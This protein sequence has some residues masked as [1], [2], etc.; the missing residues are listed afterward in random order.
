M[1]K[2]SC[3]NCGSNN[4]IR[5]GMGTTGPVNRNNYF[6]C[7]CK[8]IF[9]YPKIREGYYSIELPEEGFM[10][11]FILGVAVTLVVVCSLVILPH[12]LAGNKTDFSSNARYQ[13]VVGGDFDY[14][15]DTATGNSWHFDLSPRLWKPIPV[16]KM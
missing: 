4:V 8:E 2:P 7:S 10:K 11:H 16:K 5:I 12:L 15:I 9:R 13:I 3:P 14:K 1:I 6:C